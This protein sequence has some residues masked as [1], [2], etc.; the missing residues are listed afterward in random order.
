MARIVVG[1]DGSEH[2]VRALEHAL[3]EARAHDAD[4]EAVFVLPDPVPMWAAMPEAMYYPVDEPE[5]RIAEA[6]EQLQ[7][8]I[9][10][11]RSRSDESREVTPRIE[12]GPPARTL[13]RVAEGA[14][15]L[16]LGTRGRGGFRGLLL[17][18][19]SHQCVSHAICP[20]L[21]VPPLADA[22]E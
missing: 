21:I 19:V 6:R 9:E 4:I 1:V 22:D 8:I 17:G 16:V 7:D 18:S 10:D 13:L 3:S 2:S 12:E 11:V 14:D 15:L 20:V 5:K